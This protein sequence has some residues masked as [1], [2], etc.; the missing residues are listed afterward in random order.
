MKYVFLNNRLLPDAEARVSVFDR[1]FAY[2]DSLFETIKMLH[3]RPVFFEEHVERL[4]MGLK[5]AGFP[6]APD[7][8]RLREQALTLAKK[9]DIP[10]MG[11]L[12]IQV[13]RGAPPEERRLSGPDPE[14]DLTITVLVTVEP[15]AGL[16]AKYYQNGVPCQT[17]PANRGRYAFVK[18]TGLLGSIMARREA[19][20]AEAWEAIFTGGDGRLLEGAYTNIFFLADN[21]LVTAPESDHILPGVTRQ[22]VIELAPHLGLSVDY[23]PLTLQEASLGAA[24]AF[25]TSSLIGVCPVSEVDGIRIQPDPG[26]IEALNERLQE[27]EKANAA[28]ANA[29]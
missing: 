29:I 3:Q 11:R 14:E 28:G 2:G 4:S 10:E 22:K 1:G 24:S 12:R 13:T 5:A 17:V 25:L 20:A 8:I 19:K 27:M 9:N 26:A 23:R 15:F 6:A 16:P 7:P 21:L 18:S